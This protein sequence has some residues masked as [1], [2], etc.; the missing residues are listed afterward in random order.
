[1]ACVPVHRKDPSVEA[2]PETCRVLAGKHILLGL[3]QRVSRLLV[4]T[5]DNLHRQQTQEET[6]QLQLS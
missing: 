1:M 5:A 2:T 3:V 6:L 4:P